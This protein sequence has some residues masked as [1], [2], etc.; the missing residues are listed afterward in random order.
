MGLEQLLYLHGVGAEFVDCFGRQIRIPQEDRL[1]VLSAMVGGS[2]P[3]PPVQPLG[4]GHDSLAFMAAP[5]RVEQAPDSWIDKRIYELDAHPW[6][7]VLPGFH[8]CHVDDAWLSCYLAD[9]FCG[10]LQLQLTTESGES[11]LFCVPASALRPIGDYRIGDRRYQN[12][13][14]DLGGPHPVDT[15]AEQNADASR[16]EPGEEAVPPV[17]GLGYHEVRLRLL[18]P[19][20]SPDSEAESEYLGTLMVAPRMAYQGMLAP[21]E[22]PVRRPWGISIQLYSLRS[23]EQWGIGDFG[24]LQD[25]LRRLAARGADFILLNPLHALDIAAPEQASPYSPCDRLRLNPLYICLQAVPEYAG[26]QEEFSRPRWQQARAELNRDNWLDYGGVGRLKYQALACLYAAFR[27][28]HLRLC[29]ARAQKF[30]AFVAKEGE[31]L[32]AFARLELARGP[33][34]LPQE[35]DF[36]LYL[37]F[38]A[39]GQLELCQLEARQAG[40]GIGLVRDL[41]VGALSHGAEVQTHADEFCVNASIGAPPDPFAPQG[42]NWGLTPLDPLGLKRN[43]FRHFIALLRANMKS[44][45]A[46][47]LDHIMGLLRLWWWPLDKRLGEGAYVYYP[48]TTLLAILCLESQRARCLV[49]GEDLGLVPVEIISALADAGIYSNELF[50][51]CRDAQGFKPP[52]AYKPQSLMMLANHDVPNLAAWWCGS[53]LHLRRQLG[54]LETDELLGQALQERDL[55]K[56]ALVAAIGRRSGALS[57]MA[58]A[59]IRF[60]ALLP[61]WIDLVA[62]GAA[63]LFSVQLADLLAEKHPVNIPGTWQ[64]Y[65]NWQRR[66]PLSTEQIFNSAEVTDW[67]Q[68]LAVSRHCRLQNQSQNQHRDQ[69]LSQCSNPARKQDSGGEEALEIHPADP[70]PNLRKREI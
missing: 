62:S 30:H 58:L 68:R 16:A 44:C 51:F 4:A 27:D 2:L 49:I 14:I 26:L 15:H 11:L 45:G 66:L 13:R 47:R 42:Q 7:R 12:Y 22:R 21:Q 29:S 23:E 56:Q 18:T 48:L 5:L 35:L 37:Q 61:E 28:E 19:S 41:A 32:Q 3:E 54:L 34:S 70:R 9:D 65:P 60:S 57:G 55:D 10:H 39:A 36:Y 53:D 6:T 8:W 20:G 46:L 50:Y 64:Q 43:D 40:M 67:L 69:N 17:L 31:G 38:V 25:L 33:A 52:A 24:D 59:G 1:G 63:A